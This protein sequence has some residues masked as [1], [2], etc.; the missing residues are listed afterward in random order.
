M[1]EATATTES[2]YLEMFAVFF[3]G[4]SEAEAHYYSIKKL[5][6]VIPDLASQIVFIEQERNILQVRFDKSKE[7][8]KPAKQKFKDETK[9]TENSKAFGQPLRAKSD[10]ILKKRGIGRAAQFGGD[11]EGNGIRKLM[12]EAVS[13]IDDIEEQ[14]LGSERVA[15]TDEEI[16]NMCEKHRQLFLCWD[17]Y[18]SGLRTKRSHLT[19]AIAKKTKEFL[20]RSILLE[21]HLGMSVTPETHVMDDHSIQQLIAT[22]GFAD[23]GEDAGERNHQDEAKADRRL[24]AILDYAQQ[25]AFKSKDEV[26]KKN[27]K[28]EAKIEQLVDKN[29]RKPLWDTEA[30]QAAKRQKRI[31]ARET[32]LACPAP[33]GTMTTTPMLDYCRSNNSN[34]SLIRLSR[35]RLTLRKGSRGFT[36]VIAASDTEI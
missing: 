7:K 16:Q 28:V 32:A 4:A 15:G 30:R 1:S 17:G 33:N 12:A 5:H 3:V 25:E 19:D 27:P 35:V 11:L 21:R 34:S 31:E 18:F 13:I 29:K 20:V 14:V 8:L 2:G 22:H 10:E 9:K 6:K 24:G 26:K 23:L 36:L